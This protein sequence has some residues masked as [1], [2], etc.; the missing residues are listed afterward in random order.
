MSPRQ[1]GTRVEQF[2]LSNV[3]LPGFL[4]PTLSVLAPLSEED[5]TFRERAG[6]AQSQPSSR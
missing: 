3:L 5:H 6:D 4:Y 1:S 2:T